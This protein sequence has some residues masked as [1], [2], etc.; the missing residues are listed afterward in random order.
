[1]D[2]IYPPTQGT[3]DPCVFGRRPSKRPYRLSGG[4]NDFGSPGGAP[5]GRNR[6]YILRRDRNVLLL[7]RLLGTGQGG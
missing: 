6:R 2:T 7:Y 1:M 4:K 5:L 3:V